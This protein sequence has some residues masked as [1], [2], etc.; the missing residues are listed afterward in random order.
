MA[1]MGM[2]TRAFGGFVCWFVSATRGF[3]AEDADVSR[4][5]IPRG[6]GSGAK[7]G[8]ACRHAGARHKTQSSFRRRPESSRKHG[9]PI[10]G[11]GSRPSLAGKTARSD[12]RRRGSSGSLVIPDSNASCSHSRKHAR[13]ASVACAAVTSVASPRSRATSSQM[14]ARYIGSLRRCA[15]AGLTVRGSR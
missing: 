1:A 4:R 2:A 11:T 7:C 5:N 3:R 14:C 12:T 10:P 6:L 8:F 15:G 9:S 13:A